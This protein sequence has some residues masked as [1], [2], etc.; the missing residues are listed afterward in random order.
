MTFLFDYSRF[1]GPKS[2]W[3]KVYQTYTGCDGELSVCIKRCKNPMIAA[4]I[5][6]QTTSAELKFTLDDH[7]YGICRHGGEFPWSWSM[8]KVIWKALKHIVHCI[9]IHQAFY[10]EQ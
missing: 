6:A 8:D 9:N 4:R 5:I 2:P 3:I 7:D 10:D 1:R